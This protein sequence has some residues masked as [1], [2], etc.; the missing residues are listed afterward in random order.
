M[1]KD[2][3]RGLITDILSRNGLLKYGDNREVELLMMTAAHESKLGHYIRQVG[4]PAK[5]I[6]QMEPDTA[7]DIWDNYLRYNT[8]LHDILSDYTSKEFFSDELEWN[9]GYQILMARIHY[10]RDKQSIPP[11][12]NLKELSKYAKR[13]WNTSLGAA[14]PEDYEDAYIRMCI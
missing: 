10:M 9:I 3:L 6:F 4:G 5:G 8:N 12:N 11:I 2:Q 1:N 7:D 13:V 14:T